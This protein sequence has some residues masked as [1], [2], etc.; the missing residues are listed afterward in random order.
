VRILRMAAQGVLRP[1]AWV[2]AALALAALL[3]TVVYVLPPAPGTSSRPITAAERL[4]AE[5]DVRNT[6]L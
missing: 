1:M 3:V 5:S 2:L 6:L 4:T